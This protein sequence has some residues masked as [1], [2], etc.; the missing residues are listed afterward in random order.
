MDRKNNLKAFERGVRALRDEGIRV[1]VDLIIGLPG[2]TP[3]SIRRSMHYLRDSGLYDETQV[4]NLEVLPG[5][6]F[7][8]EAQE[9]GLEYQPRPPYYVL[10]SPTLELADLYSLMDEA[11]EL[12]DTE[13]DPLPEPYI[14]PIGTGA[15]FS[16]CTVDLDDDPAGAC[17]P[18]AEARTQA[19][20]LWLRA[21]DFRPHSDA[22]HGIIRRVLDENPH[23]TLQVLLEPGD[24]ASISPAFL[25]DLRRTCY[26]RTSYLDRFY[27]ILPGPMK[28]SK[29]LVVLLDPGDREHLGV[30]VISEIEEFAAIVW[31]DS[32]PTEVPEVDEHDQYAA[33]DEP[34]AARA[35]A[36]SPP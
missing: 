17:L 29:R 18:A 5:T 10:K 19:F 8:H 27:S 25:A 6:A 36:C 12:F 22:V 21:D 26:R 32:V 15:E 2:D 30:E 11:E 14:P 7:R 35:R 16:S 34:V 24:A 20:T 4:F 33:A 31:R 28:G 13:F 1:K 9:L 23:T 3:D